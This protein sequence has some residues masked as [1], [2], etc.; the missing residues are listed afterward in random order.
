MTK[1]SITPSHRRFCKLLSDARL[2]A[3]LSYR[4]ACKGEPY[5]YGYL[6]QI[7]QGVSKPSWKFIES[8]FGL[9]PFDTELLR[10]AVLVRLEGLPVERARIERA[11][12]VL[13][14][15]EG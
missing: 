1:L 5:T 6:Y 11:A 8:L 12:R 3:G 13:V 9:Y 15:L 2:D 4:A 14:G 7:E 10:L